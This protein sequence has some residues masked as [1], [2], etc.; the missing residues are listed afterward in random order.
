MDQLWKRNTLLSVGRLPHA[1]SQPQPQSR[2][3]PKSVGGLRDALQVRD[4]GLQATHDVRPI[5][6]SCINLVR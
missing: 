1:L 5:S 6:S 4:E 2:T 3:H